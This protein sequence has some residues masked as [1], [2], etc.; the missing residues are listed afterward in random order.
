[1]DRRAE[2]PHWQSQDPDARRTADRRQSGPAPQP[3]RRRVR[4]E[5]RCRAGYRVYY[6]QRG[7]RLLLLLAG[8]DKS[9]QQN[10]IQMAIQLAKSFQ[11]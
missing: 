4:V 10:D 9:S 5:D 11:E 8:G 2:G 7:E 1:M 3:E 6:T